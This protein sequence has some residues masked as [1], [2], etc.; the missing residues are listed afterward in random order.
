MAQKEA[1]HI[2]EP[3]YDIV[4]ALEMLGLEKVMAQ[5]GAKKAFTTLFKVYSPA[6]AFQL[7][8]EHEGPEEAMRVAVQTLGKSQALAL[9]KEIF[10]SDLSQEE[11]AFFDKL[12]AKLKSVP[13]DES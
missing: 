4:R 9:L 13:E 5:L 10:K 3:D 1:R 12:I 2:E 6:V 7:I 8:T 11:L